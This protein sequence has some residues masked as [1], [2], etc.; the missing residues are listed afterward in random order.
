[1]NGDAMSGLSPDDIPLRY[2]RPNTIDGSMVSQRGLS[3]IWQPLELYL[4]KLL[5]ELDAI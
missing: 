2:A 4:V 5:I 1:M 3:R